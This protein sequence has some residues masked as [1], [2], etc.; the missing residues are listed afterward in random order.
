ML[1]I[2]RKVTA[3]L[4]IAAMAF[5]SLAAIASND[6]PHKIVERSTEGVINALKS[7]PVADRTEDKVRELVMTWIIPAVDEQR[8]AMGALGKYWRNAEPEQRQAFIELYRESQ[9]K[10]YS[11]AFKAFDGEKIIISDTVFNAKGDKAIVKTV[12]KQK[13][14]KEIPVDFRLYQKKE[15]D[16][17][18]VYDAVVA[19]LSLV[20]TYRDQL[21]E[22]LQNT[23]LDAFLLELSNKDAD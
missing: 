9:I 17:W 4:L 19:G 7:L 15:G 16:S 6:A 5:F 11:G 8:V 22:K 2:Y 20:K 1:L 12:L 23:T 13:D 3:L 18:L 14:G 10:T 21:N